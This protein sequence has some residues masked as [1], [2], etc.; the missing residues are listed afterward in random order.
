MAR[1]ATAKDAPLPPSTPACE[2][3]LAARW[4]AGVWRG[5][6]LQTLS[7]ATYRLIFEGRRNGGPGPEF[8][9]AALE[10]KNG[11]RLLGDIELRLRARDW[12]AHGHHTDAR[13][14]HV[15]LHVALDGGAAASPLANGSSA[16][17]ATLSFTPTTF[18]ALT[19][20]D[21]PCARLTSRIGPVALRALL[22]WAG[23]ERF[24]RRVRSFRDDL[25]SATPPIQGLRWSTADRALWGALAEALGYGRH[26][27]ALRDAGLRLLAGDLS[28]QQPGSR[29]EH[30]RLVG[31]LALWER[32]RA[33]GPWEPLRAALLSRNATVIEEL[34]VPGGA[35]SAARG[36][37]MAANVVFPFATALADQTGDSALSAR[38]RAAYLE[39]P[40]L[41]SNQITREL[42]RQLGMRATPTGAVAQQGLHHLWS[43]WRQ[44]KD[45]DRCPCTPLRGAL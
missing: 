39:L 33:T 15:I 30:V 11:A 34:R 26:R 41:P 35:I 4:A 24:E 16:P 37:I 45:C 22:L 17:V 12:L 44:A 5:A 2:A 7:G 20:P 9:D 14:N 6:T 8:R 25:L 10:A 29:S 40:G 21:W 3:E 19:A 36:R 42:M 13:Y 18:T 38:A 32:W 31:L 1:R 43:S 28:Y 23:V 27:E